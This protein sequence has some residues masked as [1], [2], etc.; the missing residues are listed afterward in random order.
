MERIIDWFMIGYIMEAY[1]FFKG[2]EM[3]GGSIC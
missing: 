2:G 3:I 1:N